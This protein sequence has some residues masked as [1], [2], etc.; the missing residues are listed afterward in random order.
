M[1][2]EQWLAHLQTLVARFSYPGLGIDLA[3]MSL[4]EQRGVYRF[5]LRLADG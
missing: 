3:T 1:N 2:D 4:I 5:L